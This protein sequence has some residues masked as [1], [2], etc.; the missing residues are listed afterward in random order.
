MIAF[1]GLYSCH[2]TRCFAPGGKFYD[3]AQNFY[4][5]FDRKSKLPDFQGVV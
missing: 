2:P 3:E 5:Y 1:N 4:R